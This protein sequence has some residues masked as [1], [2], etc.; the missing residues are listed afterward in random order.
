MEGQYKM[1]NKTQLNVTRKIYKTGKNKL[2]K[3]NT[4]KYKTG[5]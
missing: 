5:K 3:Y 1:K 2:D 4:G